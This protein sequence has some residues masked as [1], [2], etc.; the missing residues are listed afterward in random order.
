MSNQS[1]KNSTD[2]RP[3]ISSVSRVSI[4]E[5]RSYSASP[6]QNKHIGDCIQVVYEVSEEE[7]KQNGLT[8]N[9]IVLFVK[10]PINPIG[11][12]TA[13]ET[14]FSEV[15]FTRNEIFLRISSACL[16]GSLGDTEC[17]C[18]PDTV[19]ALVQIAESE[20]GIFVYMPQDALG[21]GL[22]DKV[23]DHRL[24]YGVDDNG[25]NIEPVSQEQSFDI[26]YPNGYDIRAY[27][28]LNK[29]FNDLGLS[30]LS[31]TY[32]GENPQK[33]GMIRDHTK[34]NINRVVPLERQK[35]S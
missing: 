12:N 32:I 13:S 35:R 33:L 29:V 34:L 19:D 10:S 4:L 15:H 28:C 2:E 31:F 18:Y 20:C 17:Q 6:M 23:R 11:T 8:D 5:R 30:S 9:C 25:R 7:K 3:E 22:R 21:R 26:L 1:S 24:I 14:L 16:H 27:H